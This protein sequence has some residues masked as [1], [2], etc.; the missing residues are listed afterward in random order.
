MNIRQQGSLKMMSKDPKE[1]QFYQLENVFYAFEKTAE[2]LNTMMALFNQAIS[3][4]MEPLRNAISELKT[5]VDN[6]KEELEKEK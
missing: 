3:I 1:I 5:H 6:A 2:E 4:S